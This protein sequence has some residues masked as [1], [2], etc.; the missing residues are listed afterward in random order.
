MSQAVPELD[1]WTKFLIGAM[2]VL[3]I[4]LPIATVV[5][6]V[7]KINPTCVNFLAFLTRPFCSTRTIR[8]VLQEFFC[9]LTRP[10]RSAS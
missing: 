6:C 9:F 8:S 3:L 2:L 4:V 1:F 5:V 10:A 7:C